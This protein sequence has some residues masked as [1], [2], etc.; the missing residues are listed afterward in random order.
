MYIYNIYIHTY[1]VQDVW[2]YLLN[3]VSNLNWLPIVRHTHPPVTWHRYGQSTV[4]R[5]H[6]YGNHLPIVFHDII[7]TDTLNHINIESF[8]GAGSSI[9]SHFKMLR[10]KMSIYTNISKCPFYSDVTSNVGVCFKLLGGCLE[11]YVNV[12]WDQSSSQI[13]WKNTHISI[14]QPEK[15]LL[16]YLIKPQLMG[17]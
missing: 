11:E 10:F 1:S 5:P 9:D 14:N 3:G 16:S 17:I 2:F 4:C 12:I 7:D 13:G 6:S 15:T 8:Q